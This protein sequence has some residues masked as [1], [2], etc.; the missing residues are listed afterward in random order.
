MS[1]SA[2][3]ITGSIGNP[4]REPGKFIAEEQKPL[5]DAA[6]LPAKLAAVTPAKAASRSR[7]RS[8]CRRNLWGSPVRVASL[9]PM[10]QRARDQHRR[11]R[12][13]PD[14]AL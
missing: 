3:D 2:N 7:A 4:L 8:P 6:P 5:A 1:C 13:H 11:T 12:Q 10:R 9:S 14:H